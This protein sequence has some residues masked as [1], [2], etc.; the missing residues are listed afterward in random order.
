LCEK[1][2]AS[3]GRSLESFI[4]ESGT[5]NIIRLTE[6]LIEHYEIIK[7]KL[8]PEMIKNEQYLKVKDIL[9]R[10]DVL[11]TK[12]NDDVFVSSLVDRKKYDV[13]VSHATKDKLVAVNDLRNELSSM[14]VEVWYDSDSI[15]WGDSLTKKI[16]EGLLNCEFGMV[17]LSKD[18]FDRPWC[19]KELKSLAE[20]NNR[21]SKKVL[22]PLLL[23]VSISEVTEKY[24][25]LDDVKMIEY[26]KGNEKDVAL[27]FAKVLIKRLK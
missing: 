3:K 5:Q 9:K 22:L 23:N 27:L 14:G 1:Y 20:R 7:E 17:V 18:F 26:K 15:D 11:S 16:D 10:Y 13:F 19:E 6:D 24:P 8:Q 25:F 21:E 12:V 4:D 2:I